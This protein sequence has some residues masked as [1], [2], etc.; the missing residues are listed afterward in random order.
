[1]ITSSSCFKGDIHVPNSQDTAPNSNLL[2]NV[3][4]LDMFIHEYEPDVLIKCLGRSLYNEFS[5]QFKEDYSLKDTADSKWDDLLKGKEYTISG[6]TVNW[7]GLIY[8]QGQYDKSLIAYYVYYHFL[9]NDIEN[10]TGTGVST[11]KSK[12]TEKVSPIPKAVR[13]W[14]KFY[15]LTVGGFY[16][17]I[18]INNN[19]GY[20]IDWIG[21]DNGDKSLYQFIQD[22]NNINPNTYPNWQPKRFENLN[23]FGV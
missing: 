12:N 14:R 7:K 16:S 22:M 8:K 2:G 6:K 10:Y 3:S 9:S 5:N 21:N 20:G 15:E 23:L 13:A 4:E 18:L 11:K 1:M 19:H 17:P